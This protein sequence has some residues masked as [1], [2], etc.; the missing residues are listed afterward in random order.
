MKEI[1]QSY[2]EHIVQITTPYGS[3]TGFV[4]SDKNIIVTNRH[5]IN[6]SNRVVVKG[7]EIPKQIVDV[8]YTD[9]MNDIA[10]LNFDSRG[11]D[12]VRF[13][14]QEVVSGESI[15]AIG[16]PL[17]LE[18]TATQGIISKEKRM[19]NNVDYIQVDAA[20]NPGNSGGP[21]INEKGEIIGVNTFIYRDGE[22]L[23]FALPATRLSEIIDTYVEKHPTRSAKCPSCSNIVKKEEAT[24]SYCPH[25]G[26]K[27]HEEEFEFRPYTPGKVQSIVEEILTNNGKDAVISRVGQ[28]GWDVEEGSALTR[29]DYNQN[30]K[31]IYADAI[32]GTLPKENLMD[33]YTYLLTENMKLEHSSFSINNQNVVLGTIIFDQDLNVESGTEIFGKL[34]KLADHYDD[35][36]A[37]NY[38]MKMNSVLE[39][40]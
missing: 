34:F 12:P 10:F 7:H 9:V 31:F 38:G 40:N 30:N 32:L 37:E 20:I 4:V 14:D 29:I 22:S 13:S 21:L 35:Y 28:N 1:I 23:G 36:L 39:K 15:V 16:H 18:F 17:G 5:V 8:I 11:G 25:C 19:F 24:D 6:G 26:H 3:G 2:K 33:F 27:F